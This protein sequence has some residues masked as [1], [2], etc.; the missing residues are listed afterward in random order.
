MLVFVGSHQPVEQLRFFFI[1][2][3]SCPTGTAVLAY[4]G[5]VRFVFVNIRSSL[6]P[7]T[8]SI[9][10]FELFALR[11]GGSRRLHGHLMGCG[12]ERHVVWMMGCPRMVGGDDMRTG[13]VTV[14]MR[15]RIEADL[16]EVRV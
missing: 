15:A 16:R 4:L 11:R 1:R 10:R 6:L 8:L 9:L 14:V 13:V 3:V 5:I 2:P 12:V 7:G